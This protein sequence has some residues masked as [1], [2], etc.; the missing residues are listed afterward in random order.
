VKANGSLITAETASAQEPPSSQQ[1]DSG[2][3]RR[4]WMLVALLWPVACLNYLDRLMITTM[5]DSIKAGIEM[6]DAQF[7]LLTSAFLWVYAFLSPSAGYLA[8]RFSRSR[9]IIV[10]LFVWSA[11]TWLTGHASTFN[12]LLVTRALMG[13]SEACYIPAALALIADYHRGRT[14]SLA[15]GLHMSG[16]YAG[17]ALGGLG[18]VLAEHLRWQSVFSLFGVIGVGYSIVFL[19]TLRDAPVVTRADESTA[20]PVEKKVTLSSALGYLCRQG[21]FWALFVYFGLVSIANWAVYGWLP[22]Y[23]GQQFK[24]G[25]GA[26]GMSAT[27]YIQV[28]SFAGVLLGGAWADRWVRNNPC[29]RVFVPLIGFCAAGP[30]L[31]LSS[32][33]GMLLVAVAGLLVFGLARGFADANNMPILCQIVPGRYRATGYGVLNLIACVLGGAMTYVAGALR[34]ANVGLE[35]VFQFSAAGLVVA[36]LCLLLVKPKKDLE[37]A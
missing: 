8:D 11:V 3:L 16:I 9:V 14:R 21:S 7:G 5:R 27:A 29:G 36:G 19:L 1:G 25:Q 26:A 18:G 35:K 15:T 10:S 13:V 31:F 32:S 23:M 17:A 12:Q 4:A 2:N 30:A 20:Q 6:T 28:A 24:L 33:T 34:D 37:K 22:T